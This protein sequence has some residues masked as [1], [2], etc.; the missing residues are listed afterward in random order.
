M[1]N[2]L[3]GLPVTVDNDASLASMAE[4]TY[5]SGKGS[6]NTVSL[7]A[8]SGG[9]GGGV[10]VGGNQLRGAAGYGGELG[11]MLISSS[12][13]KDYSGL[14]G[15]LE[16]MVKRDDLLEV[17]KLYS[18]T[19]EELHF[20]IM[21]AKDSK[22]VK[23]LHQQIDLLGSAIGNLANIFNPEVVVL[24]GFLDSLFQFDAERLLKSVRA[25]SLRSANE[26]MVV[27]SSELG[28]SAA[29]IGAAELAFGPL[30]SEP[31]K[32]KLHKLK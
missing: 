6:L 30:L 28:T 24:A 11:H 3:S 32:T 19:D 10:I 16:A 13:T 29:L 4:R 15:T 21:N 22:A 27:R 2:Q 20:E 5:G 14:G 31:G 26:R 1:L 17:F 25:S 8:G 18:A 23:L 12:A 7:F 9:I